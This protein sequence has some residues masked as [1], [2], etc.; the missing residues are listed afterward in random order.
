MIDTY[1]ENKFTGSLILVDETTN[2]TVAADG[3]MF[4]RTIKQK[5]KT[6]VKTNYFRHWDRRKWNKFYITYLIN[7]RMLFPA[8]KDLYDIFMRYVNGMNTNSSLKMLPKYL[9]FSH[10]E[11][12]PHH[13][14]NRLIGH[15]KI[16]KHGK[17]YA[18]RKVGL[19]L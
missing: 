10:L 19:F 8:M 5:D 7:T 13:S 6:D 15:G 1:R 9:H 16:L 11:L 18:N 14:F 17:S 3:N 12:Q 4:V 2:E